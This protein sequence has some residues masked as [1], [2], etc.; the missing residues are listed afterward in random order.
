MKLFLILFLSLA[1]AAR[2][3]SD[4]HA[5][6]GSEHLI[7]G[8]TVEKLTVVS[9]HLLF[10]IRPPRNWYRQVDEAGRKIIFTAPSGKSAVTV[11]FTAHSPGILPADD[12][13]R[14]Q[15]LQAHPG[16]GIVQ[17]AVCPTGYRPGVFFYLVRVP[18]PQVVQKLRHAYVPQPA[19][20]VEFVLT[21][22]EDEF[23]ADRQ[24]FM[25]MLRAFR[26]DPLKPNQP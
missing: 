21:A 7:E 12:V 23:Q 3:Q 19:G 9:S 5:Y 4:F 13:L 10:N 8:G 25:A 6:P 16:A 24:V 20:E 18:A 26:V 1:A 17:R 22:S 11:Q 15:A 2:A 14:A